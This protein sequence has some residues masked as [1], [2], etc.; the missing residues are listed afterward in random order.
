MRPG[1]WWGKKDKHCEPGKA[2]DAQLGSWW[3][4]S[5][6]DVESRFIVSLVVGRRTSETV[7]LTWQD[8]YERTDGD[9]PGLIVTDEYSA[10]FTVLVDVYGVRKEELE[11]TEA[12]KLEVG[13]EEMPAVYF[14]VEINYAT[15]HKERAGGRV[16]HVEPRVLLGT[17]QEVQQVLAECDTAQTVNLNYLERWHG[18][19]R[20][21]NAR[22]AR[23][24]YTFSK[25]LLFHIAMTWLVVTAYNWC[26]TPRTLRVREQDDPP[27]YRQRT[28]AQAAGLAENVWTLQQVFT[29]PIYRPGPPP[30]NQNRKRRKAL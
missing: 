14:P 26:W 18:T 12:E 2:E 30:K 21:F 3:D 16:V 27:R 22:K 1:P 20:H 23:K 29:Y 8:Y 10:Y 13:Y 5:I 25:E 4:H 11:F 24:V 28:P 15:V 17:A 19:Q 9:L 6:L 7:Q